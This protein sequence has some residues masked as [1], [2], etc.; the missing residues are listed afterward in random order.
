M[1]EPVEVEKSNTTVESSKK[2][3]RKRIH[4]KLKKRSN[5][6]KLGVDYS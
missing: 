6:N 3:K 2:S 4:V 5:N 1:G